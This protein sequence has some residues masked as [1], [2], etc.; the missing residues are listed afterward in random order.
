MS[1]IDLRIT[2][3]QVRILTRE[4]SDAPD[5]LKMI[6]IIIT[7]AEHLKLSQEN[8]EILNKFTVKF[9]RNLSP[10]N[11]ILPPNDDQIIQPS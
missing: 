4:F 6:S 2:W 11:I 1:T 8:V 9:V 5:L 10:P 3:D 7:P